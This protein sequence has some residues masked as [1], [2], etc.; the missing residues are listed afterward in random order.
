MTHANSVGRV[1]HWTRVEHVPLQPVRA[2][3]FQPLDPD[4]RLT[5][6]PALGELSRQSNRGNKSLPAISIAVTVMDDPPESE[7]QSKSLSSANDE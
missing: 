6:T 2:G 4:Q 3:N 1:R 7:M 5:R